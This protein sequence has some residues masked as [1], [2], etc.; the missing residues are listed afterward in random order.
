MAGSA[1][2]CLPPDRSSA[3]TFTSSHSPTSPAREHLVLPQAA[4][5][6]QQNKGK[7]SPL[8]STHSVSSAPASPR[9]FVTE[10]GKRISSS[11]SYGGVDVCTL[12]AIQLARQVHVH[13]H[14]C[15]C[16]SKCTCVCVCVC[17]FICTYSRVCLTAKKIFLS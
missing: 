3:A 5:P 1:Q 6:A 10:G 9:R 2:Y 4:A 13:V 7:R 11:G 14:V 12:P 15:V 17:T 8:G 16:M